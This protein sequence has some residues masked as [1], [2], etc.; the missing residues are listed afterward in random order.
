LALKYEG[1]ILSDD[2]DKIEISVIVPAYNAATT[3]HSCLESLSHQSVSRENYEIIVVD[4]GSTDATSDI[5]KRFDVNY[6]FQPN[7]GPATARNNGARM[8][9]GEFILFTD[10]DCLP[11]HN[12]IEEMVRSFVDPEVVAVKGAYRTRQRELAARF[13]QAEFED[14]YDLLEKSSSIDMIDTY[15]AAFRKNVFLQVGGFHQ[16]FPVADN[17]DTELSYRLAAAGYKLVFSPKARVYHVHPNTL[18]KYLGLKLRRGYWRMVVYSRYPSK[19]VKDSYT[20]AVIKIQT[21]LMGLSLVLILF[22]WLK[23][24]LLYLSL[25]SWAVIILF[26][27]PFSSKTFQKDK[28]VGVIAP[29]VV[30]LRSFAFA[31]GSGLGIIRCLVSHPLK[32][33]DKGFEQSREK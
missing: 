30:L 9:Q 5:A 14:R 8:A 33:S 7:Q 6:V 19:A 26:S 27:M 25:L 3:L 10:S 28:A 16:S 29:G 13:A 11:E 15:S 1:L 2:L 31:V 4:D 21:L 20:P 22:S 17:E 18:M 12:W 24:A 32:T 23:P